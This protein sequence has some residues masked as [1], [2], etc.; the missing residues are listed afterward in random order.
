[1]LRLRKKVKIVDLTGNNEKFTS[2][3]FIFGIH[4]DDIQ[5]KVDIHSPYAK[6]EIFHCIHV[7]DKN[8]LSS[9]YSL[10]EGYDEDKEGKETHCYFLAKLI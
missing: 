9:N 7:I 8:F 5:H 10:V 2:V 3:S 4:W 6:P 1:M